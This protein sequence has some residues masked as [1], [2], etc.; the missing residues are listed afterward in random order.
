VKILWLSQNNLKSLPNNIFIYLSELR[1]LR[2]ESN[3]ISNLDFFLSLD[4][5]HAE[6]SSASRRAAHVQGKTHSHPLSKLGLSGNPIQDIRE[7][8]KLKSFYYLTDVSVQDVHYGRCPIAYHLNGR[9]M[10]SPL[11][12]ALSEEI[13]DEYWYRDYFIVHL[14]RVKILDGIKIPKDRIEQVRRALQDEVGQAP[15]L[16]AYDSPINLICYAVAKSS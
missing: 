10:R 13:D 1:E 8:V 12:N 14:P 5:Y 16:S 9:P 4:E 7:L 3:N 15:H 2:I 6:Q 11:N